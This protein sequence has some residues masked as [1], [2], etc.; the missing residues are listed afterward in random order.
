M[1]KC[2]TSFI[3]GI[4]KTGD[5]LGGSLKGSLD[6]ISQFLL[7]EPRIVGLDLP[8]AASGLPQDGQKGRTVILHM[9]LE[10]LPQA[11]TLGVAAPTHKHHIQMLSDVIKPRLG[12]LI[13][14]ATVGTEGDLPPLPT[15]RQGCPSQAPPY[16]EAHQHELLV[17][18]EGEIW[19]HDRRQGGGLADPKA[20]KAAGKCSSSF[21]GVYKGTQPSV[22]LNSSG[23]QSAS[24]LFFSKY[25]IQ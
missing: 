24:R 16:V 11:D 3:R 15:Y 25:G 8:L 23:G 18:A 20:D 22:V 9:L 6:N 10:G 17:D 7:M 4:T 12:V 14:K 5:I 1:F 13:S 2:L 21:S 19:G